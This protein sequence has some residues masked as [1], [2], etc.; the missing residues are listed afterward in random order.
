VGSH[1]A[2]GIREVRRDRRG[3]AATGEAGEAGDSSSGSASDRF[4]RVGP[5]D[6]IPDDRARVVS[7]GGERIAV[8]R[9]DGKVSAISNVCRHQN[10]P[11][12][13]GKVVDGCVTCP[14]HGFQYL[15]A[16]GR[17]PAP[18]TETIETYDV[19]IRGGDVYVDPSP[20]PPGTR[21]EPARIAT[22]GAGGDGGDGEFYVGYEPSMP[23]AIAARSRSVVA[24]LFVLAVALPL[25]AVALQ[26]PFPA[27]R[28]EFGEQRVLE[29]RLVTRPVPA[30]R[31][32]VGRDA[33]GTVRHRLL[34]LVAAG[35]F[36]AEDTVAAANAV[37]DDLGERRVRIRGTLIFH[38]GRALLEVTDGASAFEAV[39][40]DVPPAPEATAFGRTV[41][42]GE[43]V[44]SK[45][46]F[47]VMKPGSGKP[48]R[49]C[50]VRCLSGGI[51]PVLMM[52]DAEGRAAYAVL[53]GAE[54]EPVGRELLDFVAEPVEVRGELRQLDDWWFLAIDPEEVRRIDRTPSRRATQDDARNVTPTVAPTVTPTAG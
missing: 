2:A 10:G 9:Y 23:A 39:S 6:G 35:K 11:L 21:T 1:L 53:V 25:A 14:W 19:E 18:F 37:G 16:E 15:P 46:Y 5:V 33:A 29:G 7:L 38:D 28:F 47:G 49:S 43:I 24:G 52:R 17:A 41:L 27:S 44:D 45:C 51:P 54:G 42:R 20:K 22:S 4:V 32:E 48:H 30:L 50:A 13:E 8:F 12:G 40:G 34:P 31:I 26:E 36:G 3:D